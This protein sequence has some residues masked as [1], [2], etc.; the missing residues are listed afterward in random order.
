MDILKITDTLKMLILDGYRKAG[1]S[2]NKI[3]EITNNI[4]AGNFNLKKYCTTEEIKKIRRTFTK[5]FE[6]Q[7]K[8]PKTSWFYELKTGDKLL[9]KKDFSRYNVTKGKIYPIVDVF[10]NEM[11][12]NVITIKTDSGFISHNDALEQECTLMDIFERQIV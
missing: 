10:A 7:I 2:E 1:V 6:I 11:A 3:T 4:N 9:A 5:I 12:I 8:E